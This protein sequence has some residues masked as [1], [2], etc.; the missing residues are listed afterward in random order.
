MS[1][2]LKDTGRNVMSPELMGDV[3]IPY[4]WKEFVF[5]R[6]CSYD[7]KSILDKDLIAGER[8]QK[9]EDSHISSHRSIFF[10]ENSDEEALGKSFRVPRKVHIEAFGSIIKTPYIG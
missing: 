4:D 6:G 1:E 7:M 9:V 5:H 8:D 2:R 10:G 3:K